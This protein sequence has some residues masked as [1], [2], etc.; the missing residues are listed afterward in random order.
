[1]LVPGRV[2]LFAPFK[3][4]AFHASLYKLPRYQI[5]FFVLKILFGIPRIVNLLPKNGPASGNKEETN[6]YKSLKNILETT[7]EQPFG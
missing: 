1:M 5:P 6:M 7:S 4:P 2:Y 3:R